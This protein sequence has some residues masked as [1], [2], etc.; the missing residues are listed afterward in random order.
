MN[1]LSTIAVTAVLALG[2][3]ACGQPETAEPTAEEPASEDSALL[4][5]T[6]DDEGLSN[7]CANPELGYELSY[8]DD[9]HAN[10]GTVLEPCRVFDPEPVDL[11]PATEIPFGLGVS[12]YPEDIPYDEMVELIGEDPGLEI[13]SSD[14]VEVDGRRALRVDGVG[15]GFAMLPEGMGSY[16]YT[17]DL[18]DGT[19]V[20]RTYDAGAPGIDEKRKILDRM[21]DTFSFTA[22]HD[23]TG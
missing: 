5:G 12:S 7:R 10:P 6:P 8:P 4:F 22:P 16:G 20:V 18:E 1:K 15:T 19:L 13:R 3:A 11:E 2:A 17:I 23:E 21:I 9:W 14:E